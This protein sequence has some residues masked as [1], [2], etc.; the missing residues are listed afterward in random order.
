MDVELLEIADFL[1]EIPPFHHLTDAQCQALSGQLQIQYARRGQ[2]VLKLGQQNDA[3]YLIRTG[4]AEIESKSGEL[5]ARS[6]EGEFFG[7]YSLTMNCPVKHQVTAI[8]DSLLYVIPKEVFEQ[9]TNDHYVIKDYFHK[10]L[11]LRMH[12]ALDVKS[13]NSSSVSTQLLSHKLTDLIKREPICAPAEMLVYEAATQ[14]T[15]ERVSSLLV[16]SD[17]EQTPG[18][19]LGVV[20]D[21]DIRKRVVAVNESLDQPIR[22]I[23]TRDPISI[24]GDDYAFEAMMMMLKRNIHHLPVVDGPK[25]IGMVTVSDLI[26]LESQSSVYLV[27]DIYKQNSVTDLAGRSK[28]LRQL[29]VSLEESHASA[30]NITHVITSVNDAIT[31]RMLELAEIELLE[32]GMEKPDLDFAWIVLGSQAR[33][34]QTIHSDQDNAII[35]SDEYDEALHGEYFKKLSKFMNDGLNECGYIYCPGNIMASNDKLRVTL[36]K[37][38]KNFDQWIK[39]PTPN[40]LLHIGIYFDMRFVAG[41]EKLY[42]KLAKHVKKTAA[43]QTMFLAHMANNALN[44]KPPLGFFRKFVLEHDGTHDNTINLKNKGVAPIVDIA[45]VYALACGITEANTNKRL[46]LLKELPEDKRIMSAKSCRNLA[47]AIEL[48]SF[49]RISHQVKQIKN[50]ENPTNYF[51]PKTLSTLERSHL[52]DA[53]KMAAEQQKAMAQHFGTGLLG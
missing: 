13:E 41:T 30:E 27:S 47:E 12:K 44:H 46:R 48:I 8:E 3:L 21:S 35:F 26:R 2:R 15:E 52:R 40:A 43:G 20:T 7:F 4:A 39:S 14:M 9:L 38:K 18:H 1:A 36:E 53:F 11:E 22:N 49:I 6:A 45:R 37:W 34:E 51:D 24:E 16:I 33:E 23:M 25:P 5:I 19:L 50:H 42:K 31:C 17:N 29:F 28:A 10:A 32:Q